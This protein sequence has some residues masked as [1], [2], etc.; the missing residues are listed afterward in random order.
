MDR[1]WERVLP[2]HEF[3]YASQFG[4]LPHPTNSVGAQIQSAIN[5]CS[6]LGLGLVLEIGTYITSQELKLPDSFVLRGLGYK[7][8]KIKAHAAL[9]AIAN[10]ITNS[11]NNYTYRSTY[12]TDIHISDLEVDADWRG[13]YSIGDSIN[14][15]GCGIKF[16]A[17]RT[18]SIKRVIVRNAALHCIDISADQYVYDGGVTANATNQSENIILEQCYTF[19]PYRDDGITTHNSRNITIQHCYATHDGTISALDTAQQNGIEVDEGSSNVTVQHCTAT[20]WAAGFQTKGHATTKPGE[21]VVFDNCIA[22]GCGNGFMVSVGTTP[23]TNNEDWTPTGIR[24]VNCR[25]RNSN[26]TI[27]PYPRAIYMYGC[28]GVSI[29]NFTCEGVGRIIMTQNVRNVSL[30]DIY[31]L[32]EISS[33]AGGCI[34]LF[35]TSSACVTIRNAVS[36]VTQLIPLIALGGVSNQFN[37]DGVWGRGSTGK[38][39]VQIEY[40]LKDSVKKY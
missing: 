29:E 15:Q 21:Q 7:R 38:C 3:A 25:D 20:G 4:I 28:D 5:T 10:V 22:D 30:S 9:P 26:T 19:N 13:R 27:E 1:V 35:S 40:G 33:A 32:S 18:G 12:N 39:A 17:V 34:E 6:A 14:N 31:F 24:I 37:I 16:S 11:A 8:T 2:I 36:R 23:A